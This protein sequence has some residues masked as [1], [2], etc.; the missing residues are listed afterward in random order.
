[1]IYFGKSI[2][3]LVSRFYEDIDRDA[4]LYVEY[5]FVFAAVGCNLFFLAVAVQ[6]DDV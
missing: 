6:I 2:L 4:L 1:M 5:V 3:C